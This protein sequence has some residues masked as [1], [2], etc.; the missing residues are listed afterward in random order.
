MRSVI[1]NEILIDKLPKV[2][3]KKCLLG[4]YVL[5]DV[6]EEME[7]ENENAENVH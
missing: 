6:Q 4:M 7:T 2:L 3:Q 5:E 1:A